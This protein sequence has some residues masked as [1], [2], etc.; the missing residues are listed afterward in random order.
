[1]HCVLARARQSQIVDDPFP[2]IVIH[3][4]L[5]PDLLPT[6][7]L[8]LSCRRDYSERSNAGQ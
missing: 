7:R 4:A 5:E 1:M 2:H 3:Q 8:R 6:T